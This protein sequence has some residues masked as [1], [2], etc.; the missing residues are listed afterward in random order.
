MCIKD[1]NVMHFLQL[2]DNH[3]EWIHRNRQS[4]SY[5]KDNEHNTL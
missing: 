4:E 1:T 3:A 2:L 5:F